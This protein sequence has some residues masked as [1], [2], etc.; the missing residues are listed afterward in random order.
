MHGLRME[1]RV[2]EGA[3]KRSVLACAQRR[4]GRVNP[5]P[6]KNT[7]RCSV[8]R[9][10]RNCCLA[11][12]GEL[13]GP[14]A[15]PRALAPGLASRPADWSRVSRRAGK[16]AWT[17]ARTSAPRCLLSERCIAMAAKAASASCALV[18]EPAMGSSVG[19]AE[20][21]AAD[22]ASRAAQGTPS[23]PAVR[24]GPPLQLF[25]QQQCSYTD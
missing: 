12:G 17:S 20:S 3:A 2:E 23:A 13:V 22:Q 1:V 24:K 16:C 21:T 14:C 15:N 25:Q 9:M 6:L 11:Q 4:A 7:Q 19:V 5:I 18:S 8:K 10:A